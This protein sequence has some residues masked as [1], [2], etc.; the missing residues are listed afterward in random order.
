M[1]C[2]RIASQSGYVFNFGGCGLYVK[3]LIAEHLLIVVV[4]IE[5]D[6]PV[7]VE[8]AGI[9]VWYLTLVD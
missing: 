2:E 3:Q 6:S 8:D 7:Q 4:G 5:E 1:R 9:V